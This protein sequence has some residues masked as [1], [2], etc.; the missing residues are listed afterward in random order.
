MIKEPKAVDT[1]QDP[2][3]VPEHDPVYVQYGNYYKIKT[4]IESRQF[5]PMWITGNSGNGKDK[6]TGARS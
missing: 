4:I 2:V 5:Y 1:I 3:Q 6:R